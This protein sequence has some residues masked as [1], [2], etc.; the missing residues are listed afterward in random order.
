MC[1]SSE[2]NTTQAKFVNNVLTTMPCSHRSS[3]TFLLLPVLSLCHVYVKIYSYIFREAFH[4]WR[5]WPF[6]IKNPVVTGTPLGGACNHLPLTHCYWE[7]IF[8]PSEFPYFVDVY[9][10]QYCSLKRTLCFHHAHIVKT[11][12]LQKYS[13]QTKLGICWLTKY[14]TKGKWHVLVQICPFGSSLRKSHWDTV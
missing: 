13:L 2:T 8:T 11:K 9:C 1:N 6:F 10:T 12:N 3:Q 14:L 4:D 5:R 7:M